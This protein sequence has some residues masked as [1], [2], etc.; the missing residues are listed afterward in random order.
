VPSNTALTAKSTASPS[1]PPR[2]TRPKDPPS[3]IPSRSGAV[4]PNAPL[5]AFNPFS[6]QK[7]P[8]DKDGRKEVDHSLLETPSKPSGKT[9]SR[10]Q[11]RTRSL[12][13]NIFPNKNQI[14]SSSS[15]Y[16]SVFSLN[17]PQMPASAVSRARKRLRGEP[18]SP[19]PNKDKR[20][21]V[22]STTAIPFPRLNS[23]AA[24]IDDEQHN[25]DTSFVDNSPLKAPFGGKSFSRLFEENATSLDNLP[26]VSKTQEPSSFCADD[27][28]SPSMHGAPNKRS[29]LH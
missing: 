5:I 22:I 4:Q 11:T 17:P 12:S 9:G 16:S 29:Q 20:R 19:S 7:K 18:V 25:T 6:P 2:K 14:Q 15:P 13:P 23:N 24:D 10:A 26:I 3:L 8:I 21:R 27:A 28:P 1:T